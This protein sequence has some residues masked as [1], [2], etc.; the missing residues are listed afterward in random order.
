MS[1]SV[2]TGRS[3]PAN[4]ESSPGER[5]GSGPGVVLISV[6]ERTRSG[7]RKAAAWATI[8]PT[9]TPTRWAASMA[10]ASSTPIASLAMSW[11]PY[12]ALAQSTWVDSPVSRLSNCTTRYPAPTRPW[13]S[14]GG[15]QTTDAPPPITSSTGTPS[16]RPSSSYHNRTP[17]VST[18]PAAITPFLSVRSGYDALPQLTIA[19]DRSTRLRSPVGSPVE[20]GLAVLVGLGG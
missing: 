14:S 18:Y 8:P 15:H 13:S 1:S 17:L 11:I 3:S 5:R 2:W 16:G 4:T 19:S 6:K 20:V 9:D 10:T 7:Y 12:G